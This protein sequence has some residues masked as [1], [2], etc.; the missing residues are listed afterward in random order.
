MKISR[1]KLRS[2]IRSVI[3]ES[4]DDRYDNRRVEDVAVTRAYADEHGYPD[5]HTGLDVEPHDLMNHGDYASDILDMCKDLC[6]SEM[7]KSEEQICSELRHHYGE[8]IDRPH[9]ENALQDC[10]DELKSGHCDRELCTKC[11]S[12]L[13]KLL[14]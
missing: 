7:H 14:D 8:S 4:Y 11:I 2:I 5:D 6:R 10:V 13:S 3:K 12:V 9:V 1:N